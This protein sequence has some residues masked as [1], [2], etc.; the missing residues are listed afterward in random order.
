MADYKGQLKR[1]NVVAQ[2]TP[3]Y[4]SDLQQQRFLDYPYTVSGAG[5]PKTT[6]P[7]DHL[8]DLILQVL[9]TNPGERV[10]LPEFGVGISRLVFA[11]N[12]DTLRTSTQFLISTNLNQWLGDRIQ[13]QQVNV[14]SEPGIENQV[15]IEVTYTVLQTQQTQ[16]VQVQI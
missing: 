14:T 16:Q 3:T 6:N 9:F 7:D 5:T 15:T 12:S 2:K 8:R 10:N 4:Q 1:R 13:V 11:P